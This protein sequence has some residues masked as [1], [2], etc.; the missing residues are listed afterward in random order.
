MPSEDFAEIRFGDKR[1]NNRLKKTVD[2]MTQSNGESILG[3]CGT[4]HDAKAFYALL[5]NKKFSSAEVIRSA[6]RA[7]VERVKNSGVSTVLL[8]QDTTGINLDGH[9][10]TEGLGYSSNHTKGI[11]THSCIALTTNGVS[12]G[13]VTQQYHTREQAK[14][15]IS[16]SER[17]KRPIEEKESYRWLETARESVKL[18]PEGVRAIVLCDREGDI[19]EMFA[20]MLT[21]ETPFVVR[22][23]H[24]RVTADKYNCLCKIRQAKACGEVE[25]SIPRDTRKNK[26]ARTAKME[27]AYCNVKI[28]RPTGVNEELPNRLTFD[29]VRITE[30]GESEHPIEWFLAT[31]IPISNADDVMTV[32]GYYVERWK[33]ERFHYI[34]K[35][36]CQAEKIQQRTYERILPV[37]YIY[38]VIAVFILSMTY[39][40]R[41]YPDTPCSAFLAEDEWKILHR[42]VTRNAP[43][44]SKPISIARAVDYLGELGSYKHSHSDGHYGVKS[45][46]KGLFKLF[47]AI[48][49]AQRLMG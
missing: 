38:S 35:S 12:L 21:L 20:E 6:Q 7:T 41:F 32:V 4:K 45:I 23:S 40:A 42:L 27:V 9:K 29:I 44:P 15:S 48:D 39:C 11:Q 18:M 3:M 25:I 24:N 28:M 31:N 36:G 2:T 26:P 17:K 37:L 46:W 14:S 1:L 30:M 10:K 22:A 33:I 13:L 34:L 47:H 8:P 49:I 16:K 43:L 19:Y 5:S